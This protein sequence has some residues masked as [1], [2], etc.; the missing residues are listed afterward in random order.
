MNQAAAISRQLIMTQIACNFR[1]QALNVC[2]LASLWLLLAAASVGQQ[3]ERCQ[4]AA[5]AE[6]GAL[7][8]R[9]LQA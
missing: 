9:H 5:R 4:P 1:L 3:E 2:S 7:N 6:R 8:R